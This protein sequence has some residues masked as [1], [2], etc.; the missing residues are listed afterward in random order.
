MKKSIYVSAL[1]AVLIIIAFVFV[2]LHFLGLYGKYLQDHRKRFSFPSTWDGGPKRRHGPPTQAD[3]QSIQSW[4]TFTYINRI[5]NLP[6]DY[7][8]TELNISNSQYPNITIAKAIA[9]QSMATNDFLVNM[10]SIIQAFLISRPPLP[11][12]ASQQ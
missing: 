10:R 1:V 12:G 8:K 4:M 7:L 9:S 2:D 5:F 3:I 6:T 11:S